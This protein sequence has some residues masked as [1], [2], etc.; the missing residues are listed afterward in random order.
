MQ[1]RQLEKCA[2]T[3]RAEQAENRLKF[4]QGFQQPTRAAQ[5]EVKEAIVFQGQEIAAALN[6]IRESMTIQRAE[7]KALMEEVKRESSGSSTDPQ[8][9][10]VL[11]SIAVNTTASRQELQTLI[12]GT[13]QAHQAV[14]QGIST[15]LAESTQQSKENVQM[16]AQAMGYLS[17]PVYQGKAL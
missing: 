4:R 1:L 7:N 8:M 16:L 13:A 3:V 9:L 11:Q 14:N 10:Q 17:R 5:S 6:Q 15:A 12:N 2:E